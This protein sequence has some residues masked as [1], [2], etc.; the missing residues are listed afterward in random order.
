MQ[1]YSRCK[2]FSRFYIQHGGHSCQESVNLTE[3]AKSSQGLQAQS[4]LQAFGW[5]A[6][7]VGSYL[8]Q[9]EGLSC[10]PTAPTY[11]EVLRKGILHMP[12]NTYSS[13][14]KDAPFI[15]Q[16]STCWT[17]LVLIIS[18]YYLKVLQPIMY[19]QE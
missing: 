3:L 17:Q 8:F 12:K 6:F 11:L 16:S 4:N 19:E 10:K 18:V 1:L 2:I 9:W 15:H 7:S 5:N 14:Y 13:Y